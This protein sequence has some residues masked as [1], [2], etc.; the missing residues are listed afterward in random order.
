MSNYTQE[1]Q[2]EI[3]HDAM[4]LTSAIQVEQ[5]ELEK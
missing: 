4:T 3:V 2:K 5:S 1:Q